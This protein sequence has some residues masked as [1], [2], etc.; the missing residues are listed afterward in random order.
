MK[1]ELQNLARD[2][3]YSPHKHF[4]IVRALLDQGSV[5]MFISN[6]AQRLC[7]S[8]I[9]RSVTGISEMQFVVRHAAQI[10][11]TPTTALPILCI[12][13]SIINEILPNRVN[14]AYYWKHVAELEL[15]HEFDRHHN[16]NRSIRHARS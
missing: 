16:H 1:T 2:R 7:L 11:I 9:H 14:I 10:T 5:S 15:A 6:L 8:R 4:V 3:V 12:Y 13:I